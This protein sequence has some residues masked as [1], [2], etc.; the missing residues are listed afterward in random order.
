MIRRFPDSQWQDAEFSKEKS[1]KASPRA[2][3]R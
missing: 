3:E 1:A 2:P